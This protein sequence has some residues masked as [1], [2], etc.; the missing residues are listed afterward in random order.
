MVIRGNNVSEWNLNLEKASMYW[1]YM[2]SEKSTIS[3]IAEAPN[4]ANCH[5]TRQEGWISENYRIEVGVG[6]EIEHFSDYG[7]VGGV[8]AGLPG[9][10]ESLQYVFHRLLGA[11]LHQQRKVAP[12]PVPLYHPSPSPSTSRP[13]HATPVQF[14][15]GMIHRDT[16][17][18]TGAKRGGRKGAA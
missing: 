7:P 2:N 5:R 14:R 12:K 13:E 6:G 8:E 10:P 9:P 1:Y 17:T 16:K 15:V 18:N 4:L 3:R 11:G